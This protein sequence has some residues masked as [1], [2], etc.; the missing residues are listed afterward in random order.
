MN[1]SFCVIPWVQMATKPIGTAR[2]CCLMT[3]S[4]DKNQGIIRNEQG[5]P[6]NL[7]KDD[8]D[9]IKN[10]DK[11]REI[12]LSMIKGERHPDCSTCWTKEDMGATSKRIVSNKMYKG[13]FELSDAIEHT[14]SEGNTDWQ[15]SYWDL[16]FGNL[17]NLKCVMC[18]PA[19]SSQWYE[20]YVL[21]NNT[22]S[23]TDSGTKI[24]LKEI[25]GRY[26]DAGEYNWWDNE[27]F[28][29]R[30]EEK[31]PYLKQ[32]YLVG[33]EPLLIEPHYDF[34]Q[35]VISSGRSRDVILEYDT[36]L[37]SIHSRALNLWK[38]FKKVWLRISLDDFG[39]QFNYVRYP[40]KWNQ[41]TKNLD[42]IYSD[43]PNLK[44]DFTVTWQVLT[45]YTTPNLLRFLSKFKNSNVSVRIL[46]SP[47]YFDVA[48]LPTNIKKD[49]IEIY[50]NLENE[51]IGIQVSHLIKYLE[52]NY[53]GNKEK[54]KEFLIIVDKLDNI[55]NTNWK[56]TFIQLKENIYE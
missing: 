51:H 18:H 31:I 40:A 36:N 44:V 14:D 3:N 10:G 45:A 53:Q 29:S 24:N 52:I 19:S 50:Q 39:D 5:I 41:I 8:F 25:N 55:R 11:S 42:K 4:K 22:T 2:V 23:F 16:R 38:N 9:L 6:Y 43:I 17:C 47:E 35:K 12:R 34:L 26:K 27:G 13:E 49:L 32:V 21:L 20:D 15:P 30:L 7:G 37:T 1:N 46:S 48:I 54:I 56:E 33:G 28:W